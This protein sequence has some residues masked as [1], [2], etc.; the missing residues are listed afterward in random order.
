RGNDEEREVD[1][2]RAG[3]HRSH[4]SFVTRDVDDANG[5]NA[6]EAQRREPELDRYAPPL[7]FR[8]AIRV[9][10]SKGAHESRLA[11]I[12]VACG[13]KDHVVACLTSGAEASSGSSSHIS[14]A[15]S[16]RSSLRCSRRNSRNRRWCERTAG[17]PASTARSPFV[18]ARSA[19]RAAA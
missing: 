2:R 5:A 13:A 9:D 12:D 15:Q 11:M 19:A 18:Q 1:P 8:K 10:A 3:E 4:K 17:S 7:L 14:K 16:G 6:F